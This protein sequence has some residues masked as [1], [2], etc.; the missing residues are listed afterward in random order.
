MGLIQK[1]NTDKKGFY[2]SHV[3]HERQMNSC[4]IGCEGCAVSASTSKKGAISYSDLFEFYQDAAKLGVSL[5]ITKVEG[6]DPVFVN[7]ADNPDIPFAK[8][9]VDAID[10]GHSIITPVCTTGSWK[11]PRTQWQLAELGKL[12]SKYRYYQYP[13]GSDGAAYSLSVPREIKPFAGERYNYDS[14]VQKL[15]LDIQ[16]LT[17]NGDLDVLVYFNSNID[18]DLKVAQSIQQDLNTNLTKETLAKSNI[19]ITE[20][21][22]STLPESCY[23]YENSI[24]ITDSGLIPID[25]SKMDWDERNL[26]LVF[27]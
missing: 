8:T 16:L 21:N 24:L 10:F 12:S 26:E 19:L 18:G 14:H 9:V 11:A 5:K 2:S 20:F 4:P 23:R 13:S 3:F 1:I 7:Y 25:K 22:S 6:Y 17:N 15:L 27:N